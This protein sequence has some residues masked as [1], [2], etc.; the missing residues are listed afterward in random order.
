MALCTAL[1]MLVLIPAVLFAPHTR[2]QT[3][4]LTPEASYF[5]LMNGATGVEL[6]FAPIPAT[7]IVS[8]DGVDQRP[9]VDYTLAGNVLTFLALDPL[10][11]PVINA[12]YWTLTP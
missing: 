9:G 11:T 7:L 12:H 10:D 6:A 3:P 4:S 2:A 5:T 8:L 1:A